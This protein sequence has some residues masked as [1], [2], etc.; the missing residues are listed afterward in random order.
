MQVALKM[1]EI[2]PFR[3]EDAGPAA[4]VIRV[5][6]REV[7]RKDYPAKIINYMC[8][9]LSPEKM[10]ELARKRVFLV[11]VAEN[12]VIGTATLERDYVGS[13]FVHP[14][15]HHQG[16][17]TRLMQEIE[18]IARKNGIRQ[19]QLGASITAVNFYVKL[20]FAHGRKSHSEEYGTTFHMTK[21]M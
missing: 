13:V 14:T 10:L 2:R 16:V 21:P 11:A 17:G 12:K 15:W 18:A 9:V 6:L 7:N 19:L 5:T 1:L 4:E 3:P 8:S 20:G